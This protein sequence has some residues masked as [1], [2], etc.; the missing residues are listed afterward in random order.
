MFTQRLCLHA[1]VYTPPHIQS[2]VERELVEHVIGRPG[3]PEQW[4]T[5]DLICKVSKSLVLCPCYV[6][7][8]PAARK[9]SFAATTDGELTLC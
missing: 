6:L 7:N 8:S 4:S 9:L 3:F 2:K 1:S 5:S